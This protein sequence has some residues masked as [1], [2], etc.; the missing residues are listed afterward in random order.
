MF[1]DFKGA[2]DYLLWRVIID[3]LKRAGCRIAE[4]AV[5]R[6]YF[7]DRLACMSNGIEECVK[8]VERCCRQ[9][10]IGGPSLWNLC[11]NDL[12][13]ELCELRVEAVA[14]ADDFLLLAEG[15]TR[16]LVEQRAS[17]AMRVVYSWGERVGVDVSDKKTVC[18]VLKGGLSMLNR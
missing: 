5:W 2:F 12:L 1:V 4:I 15:A 13:D 14:Y 16:T 9:G 8:R 18:M 10:S 11:M 7:A 3:K 6:D 17:E